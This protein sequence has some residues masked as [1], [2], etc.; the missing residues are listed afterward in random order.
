MQC[1]VHGTKVILI[2]NENENKNEK[3]SS[4]ASLDP[5]SEKTLKPVRLKA[6]EANV[7][8]EATKDNAGEREV[9]AGKVTGGVPF[10]K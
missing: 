6:A 4:N 5:N 9:E 7:S 2:S 3:P 8:S 10:K 1:K